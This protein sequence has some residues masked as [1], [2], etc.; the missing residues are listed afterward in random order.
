MS[1]PLKI[2][3]LIKQVPV[4]ETLT[5]GSDGRLSRQG[6]ELEMNPYCRRAVSKGVELARATGGSCTVLTLGPPSAEDVLRE[7]I[8]WGAEGGL[9]LCDPAF[10]GSDTLATARALVAALT[11]AGPFDL[12]LLGRNT[13]D[14]ETG[15]VGPEVAQLLD[16]P[17]ACGALALELTDEQLVLE[18]E[19]DDGFEDVE[20]DLPAVVSVAERLC[21]P[22]KVAPEGRAAVT[23]NR[24]RRLDAA[25]LGP[26]PW[27]DAGSPTQ[28][29]AVR[30]T[31]QA[32]D[33]VVLSGSI[34]E[35]VSQAIKVLLSRGALTKA[36]PTR[37]AAR[38]T[39]GGSVPPPLAARA[40][41]GSPR[42][43]IV[44][45]AEADCLQVARELIGA[46]A[47]LA[48]QV[49]ATVH[50]IAQG[51]LATEDLGGAGADS[52]VQLTGS[53]VAE[54]V[55]EALISIMAETNPWAVFAPSTAFGR[56]V[57]GR[58]AAACGAG[59]VGDAIGLEVV[60]GVLVAAKP[61]FAGALVADIT[62]RSVFQLV[63]VRPGILPLPPHLPRQVA[64]TRQV[65]TP[66]NRVRVTSRRRTDDVEVLARAETVI[67]VGT[68]VRPD[69]YSLLSALAAIL[70]AELAATRKVTDKGWAP[71]ARQIGITGRAI[72][73][74]LYVAVGLSGKFN[75]MVGVRSAG[76]IMGINNDP[77]ALVFE[78]CD[79]GIVGDWHDVL[80]VLEVGL[81]QAL[82]ELGDD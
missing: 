13:I 20:I 50:V 66:R 29:G 33:R 71:K 57:A 65:L 44:V 77:N 15:Q 11:D 78:H 53:T 67:G 73:P 30:T 26:G 25:D 52:I 41:D 31:H 24:V 32:R 10:A 2:A 1:R 35:Q 40:K 18:L 79:V 75:H 19:T 47:Q 46:A 9:H 27:G 55:A 82:R 6:V 37:A 59:L 28:V 61:A 72:A 45:I 64:V 34:D 80:P 43:S 81:R 56:E 7:A 16:L 62:C 58:A 70:G 5:L 51:G 8:A 3:A 36:A 21:E 49:D 74:R 48:A 14:G 38:A 63:T 4:V 69:D 42:R 17:F 54:D 68:G 60:D 76:T 39:G 23:A 22:C 12:I